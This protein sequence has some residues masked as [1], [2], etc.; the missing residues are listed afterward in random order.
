MSSLLDLDEKGAVVLAASGGDTQTHLR[1]RF[2]ERRDNFRP[3]AQSTRGVRVM[4]D[5]APQPIPWTDRMQ[6]HERAVHGTA[7]LRRFHH[8]VDIP[9]HLVA[10][11]WMDDAQTQLRQS[12]LG[13]DLVGCTLSVVRGARGTDLIASVGGDNRT[14]LCALTKLSVLTADLADVEQTHDAIVRRLR[15]PTS[16]SPPWTHTVRT[17]LVSL[18]RVERLGGYDLFWQVAGGQRTHT[19]ASSAAVYLVD[20]RAP[21]PSI[22]VQPRYSDTTLMP[23]LVTSLLAPCAWDTLFAISTVDA[24]Q[25][26]DRRFGS[27]P[28][29]SWAHHRGEDRTLALQAVPGAPRKAALL[30]SQRNRLLTAYRAW[31]SD[32]LQ[33]DGAAFD[34]APTAH[35]HTRA[36]TAYYTQ[37]AA[38]QAQSGAPAYAAQSHTPPRLWAARGGTVLLEQTTRG[39]VFASAWACGMTNEERGRETSPTRRNDRGG[40]ART[41]PQ[42]R[43]PD[44]GRAPTPPL[45]V[46]RHAFQE[47]LHRSAAT[48]DP[49]PFGDREVAHLDLTDV[50]KAH[51]LKDMASTLTVPT[52]L[53]D[54]VHTASQALGA[55]PTAGRAAASSALYIGNALSA[56]AVRDDARV[57]EALDRILAASPA[58]RTAAAYAVERASQSDAAPLSNA[59]QRRGGGKPR[60]CVRDAADQES[61]DCLLSSPGTQEGARGDTKAAAHT[62]G[63]P[64]NWTWDGRGK[65]AL[66]RTPFNRLLRRT[67]PA[68]TDDLSHA[69]TLLLYEWTP[70]EDV[71]A[72]NYHDPYAAHDFAAVHGAEGSSPRRGAHPSTPPSAAPSVASSQPTRPAVVRAKR[73]ASPPRE[74]DAPASSPVRTETAEPAPPQRAFT[75]VQSQAVAGRF[76]QRATSAPK[77]KRKRVGGF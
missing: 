16:G 61:L 62:V 58:P 22:L 11:T 53:A 26:Y 50:Y 33:G 27:A 40:D 9:A 5:T 28:V 59:R 55:P 31:E 76:A 72:Y 19:A 38:G 8:G 13:A 18:P 29:A 73:R 35:S 67:A 56:G 54:R 77:P 10:Q 15:R 23:S 60:S 12:L 42:P 63:R 65:P 43:M 21:E 41:L 74:S 44:G 68:A 3:A 34:D 48:E 45:I 30:S 69:A 46:D 36:A 66:P 39:S 20:E 32:E 70:G 6:V 24:V 2:P 64:T 49:G 7:F 47:L 17:P 75:M 51:V 71:H 4:T 14:N 57:S 52:T 1:F 25:Y 37:D